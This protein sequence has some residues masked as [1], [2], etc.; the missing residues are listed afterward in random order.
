MSLPRVA[1]IGECMIE[2]QQHADGSLHQS[3]GGDTLNTAV[4]LARLLGSG[5]VDYVTALGDDSFSDAMCKVWSEEGIGLGK[6]QRLP[7]RLPG[8]YCI[9][10]DASGERRFLYWRNEA[11]VRDCF[12]T[13]AA[14]PILAALTSYDVLY[15]SGITLAVLGAEGRS[16]LLAMLAKARSRGAKV[17]FDNNYRPRLWAS[18]EHA[19]E[20]YLACLPYVNLAL[21]TEDDEQA[22]YGYTDTEQLLTAYRQR[23]IDEIVIKRGAQS[24]IVETDGKR[25]EIPTQKVERVVDTTAAGDSFSAAYLAA[26]LKGE[27]PQQ[28]A[29]AGHR[30]AGI[31]IQHPGALVPKSVMPQ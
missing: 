1:L 24:C 4:Y 11:A 10:T 3:F 25:F 8:L 31:V 12:M 27:H 26:R 30:L 19:R 15:F 22:L 18:V 14:E 16:R 20:A 6:V 17:A 28:A 2:L 5:Q 21:L 23:G 13:P 7:G 9:Q 29:E